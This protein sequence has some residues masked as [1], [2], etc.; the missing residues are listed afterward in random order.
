M[1]RLI[2][3]FT[4]NNMLLGL[5]LLLPFLNG[6]APGKLSAPYS[7]NPAFDPKSI[8]KIAIVVR[9]NVDRKV[10]G[11]NIT[12]IIEQVFEQQIIRHGY[13]VDSSPQVRGIVER[14]ARDRTKW[15]NEQLR[16]ELEV[17]KDLSALIIVEVNEDRVLT[18]KL[19]DFDR[20]GQ[21]FYRNGHVAIS[22]LSATMLHVPDA[23]T[24]WTSHYTDEH[25]VV[26]REETAHKESAGW[27]SL[28]LPYK[29]LPVNKKGIAF[30]PRI[31]RPVPLFGE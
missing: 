24:L 6:C 23:E 26:D 7:Q 20:N 3:V 31:T 8:D 28:A 17:A 22:S 16:I 18:R 29:V 1:L 21:I 2:H 13:R 19:Q 15:S 12:G 14:M 5:L 30:D 10:P 25:E 11:Q 9:Q 4:R 27:V